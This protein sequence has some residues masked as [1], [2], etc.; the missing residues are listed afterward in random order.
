MSDLPNGNVST[1]AG[2]GQPVIPSENGGGNGAAQQPITREELMNLLDQRE[3]SLAKMVQSRTDSAESRIQKQIREQLQATNEAAK[4]LQQ[5][6]A[7]IDRLFSREW[8]RKSSV[9]PL[10]NP[11]L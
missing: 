11:N 2:E 4:V 8:R 5:A 7:S 6:G 3:Q 10:P 9:T 1:P